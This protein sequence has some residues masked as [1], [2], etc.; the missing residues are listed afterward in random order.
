MS[1]KSVKYPR[2]RMLNLIKHKI[3]QRCTILQPY[4]NAKQTENEC[5]LSCYNKRGGDLID[6]V[7]IKIQW[8]KKRRI[9]QKTQFQDE[10][11]NNKDIGRKK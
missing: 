11:D 8:K 6:Q 9:K 10:D 2:I 3:T 1:S 5:I 4:Q 7:P